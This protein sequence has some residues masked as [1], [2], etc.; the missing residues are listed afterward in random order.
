MKLSYKNDLSEL[1]KL[2]ADIE[3]FSA[4][5]DLPPEVVYALNLCLDEVLTNIIS[6][7][8]KN[9]PD[10]YLIEMELS[11]NNAAVHATMR[12]NGVAFNPLKADEPDLNTKVED[13][14]VGGLGVYFLEQYMDNIQYEREDD[15]NVLTLSKNL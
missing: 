7:G 14:Q 8:L 5:Q 15:Q 10:D 12:D 11:V 1:T 9:K 13:R 2:A 6:Y 4:D 3:T